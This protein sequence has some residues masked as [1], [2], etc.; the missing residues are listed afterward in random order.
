[1][2]DPPRTQAL[3]PDA[4]RRILALHPF[5]PENR[6]RI[7]QEIRAREA[8]ILDEHPCRL[9]FARDEPAARFYEIRLERGLA[10]GWLLF[11]RWGRPGARGAQLV[12]HHLSEEEALREIDRVADRQRHRGY[13]RTR[14]WPAHAPSPAG[15][16]SLLL[17]TRDAFSG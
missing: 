1:M 11:R 2:A 13:R 10:G 14:D 9:I 8:G 17:G 16:L 7:E 15:Q 6:A 5:S 3:T 4:L 12:H